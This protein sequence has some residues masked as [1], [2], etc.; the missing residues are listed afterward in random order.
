MKNSLDY[1]K[2]WSPAFDTMND[3]IFLIDKNFRVV[4]V[5]KSFLDFTKGRPEDF[6]GKACY[7]II[8]DTDSPLGECPHARMLSTGKFEHSEFF[9]PRLKKWL[10]VRTT[11]IFGDDHTVI[12]SIHM[13]ADVTEFRELKVASEKSRKFLEEIVNSISSPIFVKDDKHRWVLMNNAFASFMGK[14][15]D[16]IVGK[17]DYD[18][19]P[20]S[21]A[22]VFWEKDD[23]VISTGTELIN[24][25]KF[26]DSNNVEHTIVTKKT[27]YKDPAGNKFI[28][29]IIR[30]LTEER[31][32]K[33]ALQARVN[34]LERFQKITVD[35]ELTMKELKAKI[36]ELETKIEKKD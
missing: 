24:E 15:L 25:E 26:T 28:V 36:A 33:M 23:K 31:E 9:E 18:F 16:E 11:P 4:K 32:I 10:Y 27:L 7:E 8:H 29:G 14:K 30:D 35:R 13:A 3:F 22:D 19:F 5:N 20:K 17:S 2:F 12:G 1:A 6:M 34:S 21:E